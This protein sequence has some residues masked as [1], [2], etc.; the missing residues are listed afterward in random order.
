MNKSNYFHFRF[1]I[2]PEIIYHDKPCYKLGH[3]NH[4]SLATGGVCVA[5]FLEKDGVLID[6]LKEGETADR[7]VWSMSRTSKKDVYW[8]KK[9]RNIT[10]GKAIKGID[11]L[12]SEN[13][14][15][16]EVRA[17][18]LELAHRVETEFNL[19]KS[20]GNIWQ[21]IKNSFSIDAFVRS[22]LKTENF[23]FKA[24]IIVTGSQATL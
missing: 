22:G 10:Y 21:S 12:Y 17:I 23:T 13:W 1:V 3:S 14:N 20:A 11:V 19:H 24:P 2:D 8:K 18:A 6:S 5:A 4:T 15:Y 7:I 9:A 16:N